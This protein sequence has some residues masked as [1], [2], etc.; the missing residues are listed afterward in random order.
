[1][2]YGIMVSELENPFKILILRLLTIFTAKDWNP[3]SMVTS[4]A[5]WPHLLGYVISLNSV[6]PGYFPHCL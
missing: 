2:K 4:A 3:L 5:V 6:F 1:M